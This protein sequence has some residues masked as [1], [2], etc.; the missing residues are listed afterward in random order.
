[1]GTSIHYEA[2]AISVFLENLSYSRHTSTHSYQPQ[3]PP[4]PVA[5]IRQQSLLITAVHA[6]HHSDIKDDLS[7]LSLFWTQE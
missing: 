7:W 5:H 4:H 6:Q 2:A 3:L 1:M